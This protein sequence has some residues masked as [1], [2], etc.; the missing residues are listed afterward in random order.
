MSDNGNDTP[1]VRMENI[2]KRF[3]TITALDGGDF[4]VNQR[5]VVGLLGDNGAGKSTLIKVLT[6]VYTPTSGQIFF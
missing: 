4:T 6:G 1:I 3:G 2:V 5:E